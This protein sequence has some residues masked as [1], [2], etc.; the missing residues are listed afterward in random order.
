M[1]SV[2]VIQTQPESCA[3]HEHNFELT[4][5]GAAETCTHGQSL[6]MRGGVAIVGANSLLEPSRHK[7]RSSIVTCCDT[8][9]NRTPRRRFPSGLAVPSFLDFLWLPVSKK[10]D[11]SS[12]LLCR[13]P[14]L[15]RQKTLNPICWKERRM[16]RRCAFLVRGRVSLIIQSI[17]PFPFGKYRRSG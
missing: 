14:L 1:H 15:N 10:R 5:V 4:A 11:P 7:R 6:K 9:S 16:R 13:T 17:G 2:F 8:T 12:R 3:H